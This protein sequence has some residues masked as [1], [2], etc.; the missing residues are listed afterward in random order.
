[1]TAETELIDRRRVCFATPWVELLA[2][3]P[4]G[5]SG[6]PHYALRS[7]DYVSIVAVTRED[8]ILLVRQFRPAIGR[9]SLE[10]PAGHVESNQTPAEAAAQELLEETGYR[11]G[12][13]EL[14]G[15]LNPDSGRMM[16]RS[17]CFFATEL[18]C[19]QTTRDPD[20]PAELVRVALPDL[21]RLIVTGE[22]NHAQ[23]LAALQ[24]AIAHGK[25]DLFPRQGHLPPSVPENAGKPNSVVVV[26]TSRT[27]SLRTD[28][29]VVGGAG[30]VGLP[31]SLVLADCGLRV[32]ICDTNREVLESIKRGEMPFMEADSS[33]LLR[34]ALDA[35]TLEFT[36]D[37]AALKGVDNVIVAVGTPIDEFLNPNTRMIKQWVDEIAPHVDDGQL[38]M[39][40]STLY[41]G[42]TNWLDA[43]F[44][45]KGRKPLLAFC[46]ERIV[47]GQAIRELPG[48]AQIV[49]GV[50]PA[51]E[52]AAA[53]FWSQVSPHIVRLSPLE[54]E[55]AKLFCNA[56][57]YIQFAS[58]NEFFMMATEA[59]VD[60]GRVCRGMKEHY[61]RMRDF[62]TAGFAAGPCL[63]KD[64]MQLAAF[65]RNHFSLGHA[66]MQV[67][68]GIVLWLVN[69]LARKF[70]LSTMTVGLLGMAFKADIDDTRAS[71]SYKLKKSLLMRC[72]RVLTADPHVTSD[73]N[74][75]STE[76][77]VEQSDLL[78]LCA[79]HAEFH[80][81]RTEG[82]PLI[83][84]WGALSAESGLL[85]GA[86]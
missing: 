6:A 39:L 63:L 4:E 28:V 44:R 35:N 61:P 43:Q 13:M 27:S 80:S 31:L 17:W 85:S 45:A 42:T 7:K 55:F 65:A 81:L 30:H 19:V 26:E 53:K 49:A 36:A 5:E 15:V 60:F 64:S 76:Q 33:G 14:L 9:E 32:L 51:A 2:I 37:P 67:N 20:E 54:A 78:I 8:E 16:N 52:E 79:P 3:L 86:K 18:D 38:I 57:R 74:L 59:G 11:A 24:L 83:D 73:P 48:M 47:Q 29:C 62:P 12:H 68:E 82:K 75:V 50:T 1:M 72:S 66:A 21:Q 41:P 40:R 69:E 84:I 58:A 25:L 71:L 22:F 56:Y 10:L 70:P 23:N 77:L 46:P 34:S